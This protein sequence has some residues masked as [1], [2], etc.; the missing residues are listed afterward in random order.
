MLQILRPDTEP[1]KV[2]NRSLEGTLRLCHFE[3]YKHDMARVCEMVDNR[4]KEAYNSESISENDRLALPLEDGSTLRFTMK[5]GSVEISHR[6]GYNTEILYSKELSAEEYADRFGAFCEKY[7]KDIGIGEPC[8]ESVKQALKNLKEGDIISFGGIYDR[9]VMKNQ[10]TP[11]MVCIS[12]DEKGVDLLECLDVA[13][14]DQD[15]DYETFTAG[16]ILNEKIHLDYNKPADMQ[17]FYLSVK[18]PV[19]DAASIAS[20]RIESVF[21]ET[22]DRVC[23]ELGEGKDGIT[24]LRV[25]DHN[26]LLV[27]KKGDNLLFFDKEGHKLSNNNIGLYLAWSRSIPTIVEPQLKSKPE[28]FEDPLRVADRTEDMRAYEAAVGIRDF[29]SAAEKLADYCK[30]WCTDVELTIHNDGIPEN[31]KFAYDL[32]NQNHIQT[33]IILK[34]DKDGYH[35]ITAQ[36]FNNDVELLIQQSMDLGIYKMQNATQDRANNVNKYTSKVFVNG[37]NIILEA[38][39]SS[40]NRRSNIESYF[41][42]RFNTEGKLYDSKSER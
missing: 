30:H 18:N 10:K 27:E 28:I 12:N 26:K 36:Q 31:Y 41:I 42:D 6:E 25:T 15:M 7:G 16:R 5:E 34:E 8:P 23:Q 20:M 38:R 4:M 37:C 1:E 32:N 24:E 39:E 29:K 14:Y 9:A 19:T 3:E 13:K 35:A 11:L 17:Y 2:D 33:C 22:Y 21:R 40:L